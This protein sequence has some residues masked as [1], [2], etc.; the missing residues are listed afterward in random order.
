MV[1]IF[2]T[3]FHYDLQHLKVEA[4]KEIDNRKIYTIAVT[5]LPPIYEKLKN[6]INSKY[7]R[8][9]L[10]FHPELIGQYQKYVPDMWRL[11]PTAKYIGEV[12]LDFKV[13]KS[14]H[15]LQK[16]FF[17]NLIIK[18]NEIGNKVISVHSRMSANEIVSIIGS[19]FNGKIILHWYSGSIKDQ[20]Q[21][22]KNGHYFSVNSAML[23]SDSGRKIVRNIPEDKLLLET[24]S[25]FIKANDIILKQHDQ[26]INTFEML[27]KL[28][29]K[30]PSFLKTTLWNNF[31]SL[32]TMNV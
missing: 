28:L 21:A 5:N 10:G 9:A 31:K 29:E 24:D 30:E 19:K 20:A 8:I 6:E 1:N 22:I 4:L 26:L 13:D 7:I 15:N 14:S 16:S 2:D 27:S 12:G 11:L 17:E 23:K 18:C 3:H 25:P 32:L